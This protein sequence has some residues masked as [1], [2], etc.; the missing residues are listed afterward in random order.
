[1]V[2][3]CRKSGTYQPCG[4]RIS[5][6]AVGGDPV[7]RFQDFRGLHEVSVVDNPLGTHPHQCHSRRCGG[8][9]ISWLHAVS[10]STPSRLDR[11]GLDHW[12]CLLSRSSFQ[13]CL[14]Y[15]RISPI[16]YAGQ[17]CTC[18]ACSLHSIHP[19][20]RCFAHAI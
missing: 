17:R 10:N 16:F 6:A 7:Q 18:T 14:R 12:I 11:S 3:R 8:S 13:P 19:P 20:F 4:N 5:Y 9:R 1:M 15:V 2:S